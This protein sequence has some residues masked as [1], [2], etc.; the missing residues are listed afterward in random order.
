MPAEEEE[1]E[2][3]DE[4]EGV[5][6]KED[7]HGDVTG[8]PGSCTV[9]VTCSTQGSSLNSTFTCTNHICSEDGGDP[10]E[11]LTSAVPLQLYP[12]HGSILT[13]QISSVVLKGA[14]VSHSNGSCTV[15]MTCSTQGSSINSTFTCTNHICSED[16]GD[17]PEVLTSAVPLQL[18]LSHGRNHVRRRSDVRAVTTACVRARG[19]GAVETGVRVRQGFQSPTATQ[20]ERRVH[21]GGGGGGMDQHVPGIITYGY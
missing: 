10:P 12:S 13:Y 2:D 14:S 8:G 21:C 6:E 7:E 9:T 1:E 4:W 15:T 18:Y 17:P 20:E 11:V 16:G 5:V 3:C 19:G